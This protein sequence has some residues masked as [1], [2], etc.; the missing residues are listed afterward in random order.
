M[1]CGSHYGFP[2]FNQGDLSLTRELRLEY[3]PEPEPAPAPA[4]E[5]TPEPE[6]WRITPFHMVHY[7]SHRNVEPT[8][9]TFYTPPI[10]SKYPT[11]CMYP[12]DL[13]KNTKIH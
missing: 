10:L 11:K 8:L 4:P 1:N 6:P 2:P 13:L 5:P 9:C 3:E 7:Y 12:Y